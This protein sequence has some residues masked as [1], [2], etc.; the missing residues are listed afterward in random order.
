MREII[1]AHA[2]R[3]AAQHGKADSKAVL[4]KVLAEKPELR[5]KAREVLKVV[6]EVVSEVNALSTDEILRKAEGF[7][8]EKTGRI[9]KGL[10][11]LPNAVDGG[12]RL[13]F[14]PNPSGPLH[15]GH[16]RAAVL[17]DE[18]AKRY[19]GALVLRFEDTDPKRVDPLGYDLIR[20]D[21]VWLGVKV[22]EEILQ[23]ERLGVYYR[24]AKDLLEKGRA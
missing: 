13:R 6:E 11:E 7:T 5:Q 4:S 23:S 8:V 3:N 21:L 18:Y 2:V 17:N 20:E 24:Y 9:E 12:V 16:A 10:E 14:A 1:Y 19:K 15:L 22:D